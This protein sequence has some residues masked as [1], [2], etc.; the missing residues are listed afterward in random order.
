MDSRNLAK[1]ELQGPGGSS[2]PEGSKWG[3]GVG[4]LEDPA[5]C[6]PTAG[7]P[8]SHPVPESVTDFFLNPTLVSHFAFLAHLECQREKGHEDPPGLGLCLGIREETGPRGQEVPFW[9]SRVS[10]GHPGSWGRGAPIRKGLEYQAA[11]GPFSAVNSVQSLS[12]VRLF[13]TP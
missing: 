7:G 1:G 2:E 12:R 11:L 13:V 3:E 9:G 8:L 10:T 5:P 6:S 4:R